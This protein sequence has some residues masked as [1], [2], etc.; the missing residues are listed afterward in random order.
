MLG[1]LSIT[2][3]PYVYVLVALLGA[4]V[5]MR[6]IRLPLAEKREWLV[7]WFVLTTAAF[8]GGHF[9][10]YAVVVTI[11]CTILSRRTPSIVPSIYIALLPIMPL[12]TPDR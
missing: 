1:F 3:R 7:A 11:V 6:L 8:F 9:L 4:A 10:V 2:V 12:L 5:F